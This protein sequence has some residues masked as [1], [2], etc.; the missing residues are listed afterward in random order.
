[1]NCQETTRFR[2][3][4]CAAIEDDT[5]VYSVKSKSEQSREIDHQQGSSSR[6]CLKVEG[7]RLLVQNS[8]RLQPCIRATRGPRAVDRRAD[9][10]IEGS[11]I[12]TPA[13]RPMPNTDKPFGD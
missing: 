13:S 5:D 7:C 1:M 6:Q 4:S 3:S 10:H 11:I 9:C 8:L 2:N 12:L